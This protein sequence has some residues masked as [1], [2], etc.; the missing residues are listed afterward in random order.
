MMM[1]HGVCYTD[2]SQIQLTWLYLTDRSHI[3]VLHSSYIHDENIWLRYLHYSSLPQMMVTGEESTFTK[4]NNEG[5]VWARFIRTMKM[6]QSINTIESAWKC[7]KPHVA[8]EKCDVLIT[9]SRTIIWIVTVKLVSLHVRGTQ[10]CSE[11]M[12]S[13]LNQNGEET[14]GAKEREGVGFKTGALKASY[15]SVKSLLWL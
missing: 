10:T 6:S 3:Y 9:W 2:T 4:A 7:Q 11:R 8:A 14:P 1:S 12:I 5:A 15:I 13:I